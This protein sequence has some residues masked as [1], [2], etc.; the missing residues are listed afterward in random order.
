MNL[1]LTKEAMELLAQVGQ[2]DS[3]SDLMTL[4]TRLRKARHDPLLV[5]EVVT[6]ARLRSRAKAKFG[7]FAQQML[8]TEAGLEQATRLPVAAL[9]A[10]RFRAAG[11]T[12]VAD[13][14][15]GIGSDAMAMAALG[16]E[17]TAIEKDPET[18]AL[19]AFNLA[20]FDNAKVVVADA[21][22][23]DSTQFDAAWFD[24]A[25]RNLD[26]KDAKHLVL[27]PEDFSPNLNWVFSQS[28][29]KGV[30]LGPAFPH[31]LIPTEAQAQWVSHLGDLV[32][33]CLWF[34]PLRSEANRVATMLTASQSYEFEGSGDLQMQ[35]GELGKFVYEPDSSLIR[36]RLLGEFARKLN[37][38]GI[39]DGI[40]YLSSNQEIDSPWLKKYRVIEMLPLD[41]KQIRKRLGELGIGI[42]EIKKRGVDIT[43][44]A[45]RPKLKLKGSG[46][47]T[48]ILTKVGSARKALICEALR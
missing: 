35:I 28:A 13:L 7:D 41:E 29:P 9:H 48:L 6:Q 2:L 44:E 33:V 5:T 16:L 18:A 14:G 15:C 39:S 40:A 37:L 34:G 21:E 3:K 17:V 4:I 20:S 22:A 36:S 27:A 10:Q 47:A 31:E 30:K 26:R 32:E 45:L 1:L 46:A 38:T 8:F 12:R 19:A 11:F 43:P 23:I 24:P 25:R 42:L